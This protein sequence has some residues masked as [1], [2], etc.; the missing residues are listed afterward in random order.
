MYLGKQN[1][2]QNWNYLPNDLPRCLLEPVLKTKNRYVLWLVSQTVL[3]LHCTPSNNYLKP[4]P[5]KNFKKYNIKHTLK[6]SI[7]ISMVWIKTRQEW[8]TFSI[9]IFNVWKY[10]MFH[11]FSTTFLGWLEH[12]V[13]Y[14]LFYPEIPALY[15]GQFNAY[16]IYYVGNRHTQ[17]RVNFTV[18]TKLLTRIS[19][20]CILCT[21]ILEYF[22]SIPLK[23]SFFSETSS[24]C[25]NCLELSPSP[26]KWH[27]EI[28]FTHGHG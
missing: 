12:S 26:L 21:S 25:L 14:R 20:V 4:I 17:N 7:F 23:S 28:R 8:L 6:V 13:Y 24:G 2:K 11:W 16:V 9:L 5:A 19:L 1:W 27:G 10:E 3:S 18:T 15:D 22:Y